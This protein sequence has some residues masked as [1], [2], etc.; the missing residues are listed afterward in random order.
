VKPTINDNDHKLQPQQPLRVLLVESFAQEEKV[1]ERD[2][3]EERRRKHASLLDQFAQHQIVLA[4]NPP[5]RVPHDLHPH[6][7]QS[8]VKL[9][10]LHRQVHGDD[11]DDELAK[12][13]RDASAD[14]HKLEYRHVEVAEVDDA[15]QHGPLVN[16]D[17]LCCG[18][19][20]GVVAVVEASVEFEVTLVDFTRHAKKVINWRVMMVECG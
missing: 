14:V 12:A 9:P 11:D 13:P 10:E 7:A 19:K 4:H 15:E 5:I 17:L 2:E 3:R 18:C 1:S 16:V 20:R 8:L 6:F